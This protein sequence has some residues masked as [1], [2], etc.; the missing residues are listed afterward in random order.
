MESVKTA[1]EIVCPLNGEVCE[2]NTVL[3][4]TPELINESS[5]ADGWIIK[6]KPSDVTQLEKLMSVEEYHQFLPK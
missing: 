2:V 6:F 3:N 4:K 5:E 1:S